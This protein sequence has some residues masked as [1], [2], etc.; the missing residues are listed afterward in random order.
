MQF[1]LKS[2]YLT[3]VVLVFLLYMCKVLM[4]RIDVKC[5]TTVCL[6]FSSLGDV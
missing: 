1:Y 3:N 2:N 6:T 5:N 4:Q